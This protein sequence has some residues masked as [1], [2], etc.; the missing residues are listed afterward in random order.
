MAKLELLACELSLNLPMFDVSF[1]CVLQAK[2]FKRSMGQESLK[3]IIGF[4]HT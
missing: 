1:H 3:L 4:V 2:R